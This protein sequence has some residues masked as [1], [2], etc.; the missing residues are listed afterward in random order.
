MRIDF[1]KKNGGLASLTVSPEERVD[2]IFAQIVSGMFEK[3]WREGFFGPGEF[4]EVYGLEEV[5][6]EALKKDSRGGISGFQDRVCDV[7]E[8]VV[9]DFVVFNEIPV[10]PTTR[11]TVICD[12]AEI[13]DDADYPCRITVGLRREPNDD[14]TR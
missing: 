13:T 3:L 1:R 9:K 12:F 7:L 2:D 8:A 6:F 5:G 14:R 11:I 4:I 10:L